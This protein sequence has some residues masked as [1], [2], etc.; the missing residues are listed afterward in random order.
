MSDVILKF[1]DR[2]IVTNG[3]ITTIGRTSENLIAITDDS[4]VS[5]FH[6][7]I[8]RRGDDHYLIDLGSS[9]GT[10]INGELVS[11]E[12]R[13]TNGDLIVFGGSSE[14]EFMIRDAG[15]AQQE[16]FDEPLLSG[17]GSEIQSIQNEAVSAAGNAVSSAAQNSVSPV[18]SAGSN[19]AILVA[20]AVCGLALVC[21]IGAAAFYATRGSACSA[22]ATIV[23]PERGET[24]TE[25]T[26]IEVKVTD[27]ECV[28]AAVYSID[29]RQIA[30]GDS[31]SFSAS[32][33]PAEHPELADGGD[34]ELSVA[35][36]DAS[37]QVIA[38]SS[39]GMLAFETRKVT[40]VATPLVANTKVEPQ[41]PATTSQVSLIQMQEMAQRFAKQFAPQF[42]Y[43]VSNKQ[44]LQEAQKRTSEFALTGTTQRAAGYRDAINS[45]FVREQN[46]EPS[47]GFI[48]AFS[49]SRF[50]PT[51]TGDLEGLWQMSTAFVSDN[52][53]NGQCGS[54]TLSDASQNCAARAAALYM[55]AIVYGVFEG[56]TLYSVAAF[57]KS[58]QDAATWKATLP[59]DRSDF[60]NVIK[61]A[62]EREQVV[63]FFAAGIVAENPVRF[64]MAKEPKISTLY[65][66]LTQ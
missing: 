66:A 13:L 46:L 58:A 47:L 39:V 31:P 4:N 14:M 63:R 28:G 1:Q 50:T 21:V 44:F 10:T 17:A 49:R 20:G 36:V 25:L 27:G 56:D 33:D 15:N 37:G 52:K 62:P 24:I 34:H 61:S 35:L 2:E 29:G 65:P 53:Y 54:E 26:D 3:D 59:A 8:E 22:T 32:I 51:K 55:K 41:K 42:A 9:N 57:G 48:L 18:A 19:P 45:A 30:R 23:N 7:E 38:T 43:N 12:V 6:A 16:A 11:P 40:P 60:W 5:R 64:G